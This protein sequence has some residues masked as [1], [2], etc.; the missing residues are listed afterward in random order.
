MDYVYTGGDADDIISL[1][2]MPLPSQNK[3][4]FKFVYKYPYSFSV[5]QPIKNWTLFSQFSI[6][7]YYG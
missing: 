6:F 2:S 3:Q 1:T 5:R 7:Q 4:L